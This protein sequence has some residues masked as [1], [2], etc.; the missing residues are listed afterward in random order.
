MDNQDLCLQPFAPECISQY[1]SRYPKQFQVLMSMLCPRLRI[2]VDTEKRI[3]I[4]IRLA[5]KIGSGTS[6][7]KKMDPDPALENN[8]D[9]INECR[10]VQMFRCSNRI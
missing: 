10:N 7:L 9:P 8:P 4:R 5:K 2:R 1:L 3:R 6:R